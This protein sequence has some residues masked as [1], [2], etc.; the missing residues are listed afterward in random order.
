M[1]YETNSAGLLKRSVISYACCYISSAI[2]CSAAYGITTATPE[3]EIAMAI[4]NFITGAVGLTRAE[5]RNSRMRMCQK[6]CK[7]EKDHR[8]NAVK[9][10]EAYGANEKETNKLK[11]AK[12][13]GAIPRPLGKR[14][15][16]GGVRRRVRRARCSY[17]INR[18]SGQPRGVIN[19]TP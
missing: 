12:K 17:R 16:D 1:I 7:T 19:S 2:S 10:R 15:C 3:N 11:K 14:G 8:E 4:K 5:L 9:E 13:I 6:L 18:Q